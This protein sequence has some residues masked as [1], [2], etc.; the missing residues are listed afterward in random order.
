MTLFNVV[1]HIEERI[2]GPGKH[3][4]GVRDDDV[5]IIARGEVQK[6]ATSENEIRTALTQA[7]REAFPDKDL[8]PTYNI[9]KT[10]VI[11]IT[12]AKPF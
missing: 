11:D 1:W 4:D 5:R 6:E 2:N 9:Y 8:G 7:L 3:D 10:Y 12:P